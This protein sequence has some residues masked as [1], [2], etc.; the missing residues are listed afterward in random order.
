MN[1]IIKL[2][3]ACLLIVSVLVACSPFNS[4]ENSKTELTISIAS[5]LKEAVEEIKNTYETEN[6][7]IKLHFNFGGSGSLQQQISQG[8]PVDLFFSAAEDK[9]DLLVEEGLIDETDVTDLL[10]N[11]LVLIVPNGKE[12]Y[13]SSF[14]DLDKQEIEKISIGTPET[15]PAGKY[16]KESLQNL[17]IWNDIEDK[18][19][20]AKDVRQVLSY[21]ETGNVTAGI[22][23][24]TDVISSEKVKVITAAEQQTH[25][26]ITYPLGILKKTKHYE[27]AKDFYDYLQSEEGLKVFKD[28]GFTI[29]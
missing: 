12:T 18:I 24:K 8:A 10:G 27:E 23:Y 21:V 20:F 26:V 22:V 6:P 9:L 1:N 7:H 16:A 25:T 5:S 4:E 14:Q 11:E 29:N 15:V 19:V 2:I 3:I 17:G 28:Y 13:I